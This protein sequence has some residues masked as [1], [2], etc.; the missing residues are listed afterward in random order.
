S[1]NATETTGF[2]EPDDGDDRIQKESENV[3]NARMVSNRASLRIQDARGIR[4]PQVLSLWTLRASPVKR[5]SVRMRE[6]RRC[7]SH[8]LDLTRKCRDQRLFLIPDI[9]KAWGAVF[10]VATLP[11]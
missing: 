3:A 10:K 9:I 7:A 5:S 6:G 1:N 11:R 4:L 2:T 8:Q